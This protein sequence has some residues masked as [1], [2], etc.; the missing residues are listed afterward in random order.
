MLSLASSVCV[1]LSFG[2]L[3][4]FAH[5]HAIHHTH[6]HTHTHLHTTRNDANILQHRNAITAKSPTDFTWVKRFAAIGDSFTAGIG[7]GAALGSFFHNK[8]DWECSRYDQSYPMF[9]KNYLGSAIDD[10]QYPACSGDKSWQIYEQ[11]K[12]LQGNIDLLTLTAGGNDLCLADIIKRCIILPYLGEPTCDAIIEKANANLKWIMR[13]NIKKILLALKGKMARDGIV[14]IN[15]YARYFNTENE[16]CATKQDWTL[17]NWIPK[18]VADNLPGVRMTIERRKMYNDM[19]TGLNDVIRDVVVEVQKEVNYT[20]GFSDWDLWAIEGVRGQ[21][22]DPSSSGAYPDSR[23]PD[24]IFFK[25]NS[26]PSSWRLTPVGFAKR[27][28]DSNINID[29]N[30]TAPRPVEIPQNAA[31]E[32]ELNDKQ[33]ATLRSRLRRFLKTREEDLDENGIHRSVYKSILWNSANPLAGALKKLNPRTPPA[34]PGCPGDSEGG[35]DESVFGNITPDFFGRIFHPNELGHTAIASFAIESTM[36]LRARVLGVEPQVCELTTEFKCWQKEGRKGY[37]TAD[38][39]DANYKNFCNKVKAPGEGAV[40]W[41]FNQTY[42]KNTPD[43]HEFVFE[44]GELGKEFRKDECLESFKRI[45]H[46][47]DGNDPENPLNWKFG[48]IWKRDQY[49][50]TVNVKRTNRPWPLKKPYGVCEGRNQGLY[51]KFAIAGM[52]FFLS[53]FFRVD[54]PITDPQQARAFPAGTRA[55]NPFCRPSKSV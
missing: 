20:I 31:A 28:L 1:L 49:T 45:I 54:E 9:I 26:Q 50:Y 34:M 10:F 36:A 42:H 16:D 55:V 24:L 37:A 17:Y 13:D 38:R 23:Q 3:T 41:R 11:A 33:I 6:T 47:C 15:S 46:G 2:A 30:K 7:S 40:G 8:S 5:P 12:A 52:F 25:P 19:T 21:M 4:T 32:P 35:E 43:E 51:S 39:M 27:D 29:Q 44:L 18:L 14:V 22:C 48:G 53:I